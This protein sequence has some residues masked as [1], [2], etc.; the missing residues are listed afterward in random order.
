MVSAYA[1]DVLR[2]GSNDLLGSE[3]ASQGAWELY[4]RSYAIFCK[5]WLV[6]H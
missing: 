2:L 6:D 3:K 1:I 5:T 4:E